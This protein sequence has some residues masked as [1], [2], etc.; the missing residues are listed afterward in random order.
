LGRDLC[1]DIAEFGIR[2]DRQGFPRLTAESAE[3]YREDDDR[4]APVQAKADELI[5]H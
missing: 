1:G 4:D 2:F 3:Q 5:N